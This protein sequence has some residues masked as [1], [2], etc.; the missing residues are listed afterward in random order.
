MKNFHLALLVFGSLAFSTPPPA[1]AQSLT[2]GLK[3]GVNYS[4]LWGANAQPSRGFHFGPQGGLTLHYVI[5]GRYALQIDALYSQ[6]GY[7]VTSYKYTNTDGT[8][9]QARGTQVLNYLD[10]PIL[11]QVRFGEFFVEGG[12]RVAYL[13]NSRLRNDYKVTDTNGNTVSHRTTSADK[14]ALIGYTKIDSKTGGIPG[15]DIGLVAGVGYQVRPNIS[16]GIR[17]DA[18]VKSLVDTRRTPAGA[19]PRIFNQAFQ[20]QVGYM[21]GGA[22]Q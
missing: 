4:N 9:F 1:A 14:E 7:R 5:A 20:A 22:S 13:L 2:Y 12:P 3:A 21:F 18:G 17:Y 11:M 10:V 19:E 15:F 16:V 6:K 8:S